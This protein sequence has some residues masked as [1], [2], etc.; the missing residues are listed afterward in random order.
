LS[1]KIQIE[2]KAE[3][4]KRG[5]PSP[6]DWDALV[7]AFA[8]IDSGYDWTFSWVGDFSKIGKKAEA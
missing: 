6:D 2:G 7:L 3:M 8:D 1:V 5:L 4:K